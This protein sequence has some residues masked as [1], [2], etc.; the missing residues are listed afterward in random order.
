MR[1]AGTRCG[2]SSTT[3]LTVCSIAWA[4]LDIATPNHSGLPI[5]E[6]PLAD[7]DSI[8]E[9]GDVLFDRGIYATMAA[10]PLVPRH[11][12]GIH[13]QLT[14]ANTDKEVDHLNEVLGEVAQRFQ[15]ARHPQPHID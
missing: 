9:V 4:K 13:L 1:S 10:Y 14:A 11:E 7:A 6:I 5:I 12:V 3:S 8:D 15:L 2:P